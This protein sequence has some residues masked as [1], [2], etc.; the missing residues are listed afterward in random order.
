MEYMR[1]EVNSLP[2]P[3]NGDCSC[4]TDIT[5]QV[6]DYILHLLSLQPDY[7]SVIFVDDD[8]YII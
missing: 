4:D 2:C 7:N 5:S 6:P 8:R 3:P 1:N